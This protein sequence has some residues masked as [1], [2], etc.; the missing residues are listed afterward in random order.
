M[1]EVQFSAVNNP[2]CWY[3]P[4]TGMIQFASAEDAKRAEE[5]FNEM[6]AE[7]RRLAA[8]PEVGRL[9]VAQQHAIDCGNLTLDLQSALAMLT[10]A[11]EEAGWPKTAEQMTPMNMARAALKKRLPPLPTP[12]PDDSK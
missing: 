7:I 6:A 10:N 11:C 12:Q 9:F 1:K 8:R 3:E 2:A 4:D 5:L